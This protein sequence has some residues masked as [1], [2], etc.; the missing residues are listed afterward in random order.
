KVGP[1]IIF[2]GYVTNEPA[3]LLYE[4]A[5]NSIKVLP[6]F[7]QKDNE[8]MELRVNENETFNAVL[9]DRSTRAEGKLVFKTFDARGELLLEDD[10]TVET[11]KTLQNSLSS[12]LKR[13]ELLLLGTWGDR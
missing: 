6:G 3:I 12:T 13:D 7:F 10:V 9:M 4:T 5:N 8:L 2:G 1:N 11:D